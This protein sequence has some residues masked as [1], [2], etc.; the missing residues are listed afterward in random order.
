MLNLEKIE[1]VLSFID[2]TIN[3]FE[4][5]ELGVTAYEFFTR[6]GCGE[7]YKILKAQYPQATMRVTSSLGHVLTEIDG[8]LYDV[9]GVFSLNPDKYILASREVE[10]VCSNYAFTMTSQGFFFEGEPGPTN[11]VFMDIL[12]NEF[13]DKERSNFFHFLDMN[14][15]DDAIMFMS[16]E[17]SDWDEN[18][19]HYEDELSGL[20]ILPF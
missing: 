20:V 7:M 6:G 11:A 1:E 4:M 17:L 8:V 9:N 16:A 2:E 18:Q 10:M 3:L 12:R 14:E 13:S 15:E 19:Q 5:E